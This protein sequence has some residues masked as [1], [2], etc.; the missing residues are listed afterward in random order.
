MRLRMISVFVAVLLLFCGA[1]RAELTLDISNATLEELLA[2]SEAISARIAELR[3]EMEEQMFPAGSY[4]VGRDMYPGVYLLQ[5]NEAAL[6]PSVILRDAETGDTLE[7]EMITNQ[8]VVEL[9]SGVVMQLSDATAYPISMVQMTEA[10]QDAPLKAGGYW[11]GTQ[12]PA[13]K[14]E[15]SPKKDAIF[16]CYS[17]YDGPIGSDN[18]ILQFMMVYE[19]VTLEVK[20]GQYIS[21]SDC[22]MIPAQAK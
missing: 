18:H 16:A 10:S 1:A 17:L 7:F 4:L 5:E 2:A 22:V 19:P 3:S 14:Y 20:E 12:I 6:L 11:I 8:I 15:I 21:I 9:H 13:G